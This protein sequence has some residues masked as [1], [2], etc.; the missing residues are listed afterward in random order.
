M[1]S[2]T[3]VSA[4][5]NPATSTSTYLKTSIGDTGSIAQSSY[6]ITPSAG[7]GGTISPAGNVMSRAG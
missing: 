1:N 2:D 6:T 3:N 5:F 7:T 4:A